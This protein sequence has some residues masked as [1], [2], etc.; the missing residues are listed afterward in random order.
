MEETILVVEDEVSRRIT[1]RFICRD[2]GSVVEARSE[3]DAFTLIEELRLRGVRLSL[4][5]VDLRLPRKGMIDPDAGFSVIRRLV[6]DF[7]TT[8]VIVLT[9]R[10]DKAAWQTASGLPA[11]R[12]LFSKPYESARFREAVVACMK[13]KAKGLTCVGQFEDYDHE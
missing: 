5:V 1:L 11:I 2:F 3:P 12:Y 9:I 8:P 13:G 6:R 10:T 7:P 4:A